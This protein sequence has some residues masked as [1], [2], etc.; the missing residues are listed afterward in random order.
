ME[1]ERFLHFCTSNRAFALGQHKAFVQGVENHVIAVFQN[2]E[3]NG[4]DFTKQEY[5]RLCSA[6]GWED[7]PDCADLAELAMDRGYDHF[8][9]LVFVKGQM[10]LLA[11]AGLYHLWERTLKYFLERESHFLPEKC[12]GED[13]IKTIQKAV[14]QQIQK[15]LNESN[16]SEHQNAQEIM[17][18]LH[19]LSLVANTAKHGSGPSCEKLFKIDS[20][21]FKGSHPELSPVLPN[22]H[23]NFPYRANPENLWVTSAMFHDF[24]GIIEQ[25][26]NA[27]P[28][29][30][31]ASCGGKS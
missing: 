20:D 31:H 6:P 12:F 9:N 1:S 3:Q 16:F 4:E 7:G 5:N 25:F 2:I 23:R 13:S 26:W 14:F 30:I 19:K 11:T 29:R 17:N 28:E 21:F 18:C 8:Q 22:E 24:A 27:M 10:M 15:W